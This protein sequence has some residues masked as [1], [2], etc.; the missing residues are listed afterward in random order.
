MTSRSKLL[1]LLVLTLSALGGTRLRAD[2]PKIIALDAPQLWRRTEFRVENVAPAVNNFDPDL[3]RLDA[4]FISPSGPRVV[5]PAFWYQGFTR[6][7]TESGEV[8]LAAGSPEWRIRFTPTEPGDYTLSLSVTVDGRP[9]VAP[10]VT[11]FAVPAGPT[12]GR[13]GWVQVSPDRRDFVV[14]GRPLR[15]VGENVCWAGPGGTY[16]Y[17]RWFG[18]MQAAGENFTRLW[19]SPWWAGIEHQPGTLNHYDLKS[20]WELDHIFQLAERDGIYLLFC[21]DHHGMFQKDSQSWGSSNNFWKANPYNAAN[22]GPCVE[23]NDFFTSPAARKIYEKRLRYLVG[24]YGYS[25][26]LLAWELFNEIDNVIGPD[27]LNDHDV[28][29][30]HGEMGHWLHAHDPYQHLVTTSLT[31]GSDRPEMWTVPELDFTSYHSYNEA[32]TIRGLPVLAASFLKRYNK[33][34]MIG[35]FGI[36]SHG[37]D[38]AADPYLRGFRQGLWAAALGGTV[39]SAMSW[40]WED[41]DADDVYPLYAAMVG[42][43][44]RAGWN[45]DAWTPIDF[46]DHGPPPPALADAIPGGQLFDAEMALN[47]SRRAALTNAC[48]VANRLAAERSAEC[49]SKYLQGAD[50]PDL[51]R[52]IRLTAWFGDKGKLSLHVQAVSANAGLI[53]RVD[54]AEVLREAIAGRGGPG[55]VRSEVDREYS[56]DVTPGKHLVELANEGQGWI[57]LDSIRLEQIRPAGYAGDWKYTSDVVG[58]RSGEKAVLYVCSP[59]SVFPAGARRYNLPP[60]TGQSITLPDWPAGHFRGE[61]FSPTTGSLVGRT[62]ST[63]VDGALRVPLPAFRDDMAGIVTAVEA[64]S[65]SR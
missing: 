12:D 3:I 47:S 31:G 54:G 43:L 45:D 2:S 20:A 10:V 15:L 39:G 63:T 22:G 29:A 36:N 9:P 11:H 38:I 8:L 33:P 14:A 21:L 1:P 25:P 60:L 23:L 51:R 28:V 62:D 57:L 4:T 30:W 37:W 64:G 59:A 6:T 34:V 61:W 17:D 65:P 58:L 41:I 5:V 55:M 27:R 49:L 19:M 52:P 18:A 35:E 40:W 26:R 48:A 46:I 50:S 16:E 32:G 42:V 44:R 24:R 56:C 53:V 7:H 13:A